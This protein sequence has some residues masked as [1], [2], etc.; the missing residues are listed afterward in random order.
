M[1]LLRFA[2][3]LIL[4]Y[5]SPLRYFCEAV[6]GKLTPLQV[7][8]FQEALLASFTRDELAQMIQFRLGKNL[9][10]LSLSDSLVMTVY[11]LIEPTTYAM[12]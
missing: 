6:L 11:N 7:S 10:A 9:E 4:S 12:R 2:F 5:L 3:S 8:Q 1:L